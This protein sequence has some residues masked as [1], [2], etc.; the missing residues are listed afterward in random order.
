MHRIILKA[1]MKKKKY[2]SKLEHN[3]SDSDESLS[4][5]NEE[6]V[7]IGIVGSI[8]NNRY[9]CLKYLGRGTFSKVW[10]VYDI[11]EDKFYAMKMQNSTYIED[12]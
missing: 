11:I 9:F 4:S 2:L 7:S 5:D 3:F 12:A 6:E 10:L 1:Q 8:F